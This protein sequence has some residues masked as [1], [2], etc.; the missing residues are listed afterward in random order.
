M[1]KN[2]SEGKISKE[3]MD[4]QGSKRIWRFLSIV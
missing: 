3:T 2:F 4:Q 1:P